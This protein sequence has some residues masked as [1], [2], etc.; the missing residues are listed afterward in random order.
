MSGRAAG[1]Y[2]EYVHKDVIA[3][4]ADERFPRRR[5]LRAARDFAHAR[6]RG[7]QVSGPLLVLSYAR[8]PHADPP[9]ATVEA[10][11]TPPAPREP[12]PSRVGFSVGKRVGNAVTRNRVKR[13]LREITRRCLG[14]IAPGWDIIMS[15]RTPAAGATYNTLDGEVHAL[16]TRARLARVAPGQTSDQQH[17]REERGDSA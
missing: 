3:V 2:M 1:V 17:H 11:G 4:S 13:R 16:L 7:R 14:E 6:K 8:I 12:P 9:V 10:S 5:R 15:A